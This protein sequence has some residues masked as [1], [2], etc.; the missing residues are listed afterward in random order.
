MNNESVLI[1][2]PLPPSC[3]SPNNPPGS[4]GGRMKKAGALKKCRKLAM[5]LTLEEDIQT[6][7]WEKAE[8]SAVFFHK[9]NRGRDGANYNAMLKGYFDGIVDAGLV[10]DDNYTNWTTMPPEFKID[11]MCSRVEITV[12]RVE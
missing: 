3:L 10:V 9:Q 7:P 4:F 12:L 8:V 2:L 1:I 11:K 5:K 6:G